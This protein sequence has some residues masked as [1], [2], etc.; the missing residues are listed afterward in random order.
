MSASPIRRGLEAVSRLP[1][2]PLAEISWRWCFAAAVWLAGAATALSYLNS[3]PVSGREQML[4]E[5]G[6]P[7]LALPAVAH[8]LQGSAGRLAAGVIVAGSGIALLWIFGAALGRL[9]TLKALLPESAG[10]YR[11]LLGLSFLRA[12]LFLAALLSACG[13]LILAGFAGPRGDAAPSLVLA[14]VLIACIWVV[15][16]LLN[17]LLSLA[18]VFVPGGRQDTFGAVA[19][20][21][22]LVRGAFG[23]VVLA[24]LPFVLLHYAALAAAVA[25]ALLV[26][27]LM[28][29]VSLAAGWA[30]LAIALGYFAYADFL[31]I[32][33]L[34]A[35]VA[36]A[37]GGKAA[38]TALV[39]EDAPGDS[40]AP[41]GADL[42]LSPEAP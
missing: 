32:V 10:A 30:L 13:A 36:L 42:S 15:W 25:G 17:W 33:R 6:E 21:V 18:A 41:T 12:G 3:I 37:R 8:A 14:V 19:A 31:Y 7:L 2:L 27:D 20:A 4:A 34:A 35:Y 38:A 22:E 24:S 29:R 1:A 11:P 26:F 40:P 39:V 16:A 5:S 23:E 28:A 9:I